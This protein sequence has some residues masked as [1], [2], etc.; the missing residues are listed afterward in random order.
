MPIR[1]IIIEYVHQMI[2]STALFWV[3]TQRLVVIYYLIFGTTY[4]SQLQ[5]SR[6][7]LDS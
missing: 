7:L 2:L 5:E 6:F 3:I 4:R 1:V